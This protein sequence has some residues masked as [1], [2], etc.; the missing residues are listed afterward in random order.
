MSN[1]SSSHLTPAEPGEINEA[2]AAP[3]SLIGLIIVFFGAQIVGG[4]V[5]YRYGMLRGWSMEYID[6]WVT[7]SV[8]AQFVYLLLSESLVLLGIFGLMR[9]LHWSRQSIGL[10]R[11]KLSQILIGLVASVPYYI[12][13]VLVLVV[14]TH[15]IPSL[16]TDQK[17]EIGFDSVKGTG[18]LVMTFISLVILPPLVEEIAMRGFLYTGLKKWLPK[19]A[20]A[21]LVSLVFGAAHLSEGGDAGPLWVGALDTFTLSLVL[22]YLR[23]KTGSLWAGIT[24]HAVKNGTAFVFLFIIG[25]K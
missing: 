8:A 20:A 3:F 24:L 13:Y 16:N 1:D 9:I 23:E 2:W 11:P 22:V 14:V 10:T 15:F 6:N 21:I 19:I 7:S 17:Q 18:E 25:T 12:L 5:L 4:V